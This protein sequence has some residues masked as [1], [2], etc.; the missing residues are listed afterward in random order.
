MD[1]KNI[2]VHIDSSERCAE[3]LRIAAILARQHEA[4]LSG[5][6]VIPEPFYPIYAESAFVSM[7]LIESLERES[8]E[9]CAEAQEKF[10][11]F[12][13]KEN[14][15]AEWREE[16]GSIGPVVSRHGRYADLT[17]IGKG[18]LEEPIKYPNAF[19]AADVVM[20]SGRPVL[21]IPN[22]GHFDG[23]GRRMM[24]CWNA[25][26]EAVRAVNDALPLLQA[27]DKVTVLAVN[28]QKPASGDH[29]EIPC[30][31]IALHLARHGVKAEAASIMTEI[32]DIGEIILSRAFDLDI[33]LIVS[34]A[35]GHSRTREWILGG[36]TETVLSDAEV[37]V[38]LAH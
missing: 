12:A 31:D 1:I 15:P 19:L 32:D 16:Q 17:I 36:V 35:Y 4:H 2:L 26:R 38:F 23:V 34:G 30:A 18:N 25:S 21:V 9:G 14:L 5:L 6:Y 22:E 8:R 37:P 29:G 20:Q 7:D 13:D 10:R 24:V 28:P 11:A 33:D 3:R 27:A